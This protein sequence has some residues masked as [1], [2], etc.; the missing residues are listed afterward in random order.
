M[1]KCMYIASYFLIS[2]DS[3]LEMIGG[4]DDACQ[5]VMSVRMGFLLGKAGVECLNRQG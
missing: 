4:D 2:N 5:A 3:N 1:A